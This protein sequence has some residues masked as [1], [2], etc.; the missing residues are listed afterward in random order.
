MKNT[1]EFLLI[2]FLCSA[3]LA[4]ESICAQPSAGSPSYKKMSARLDYDAVRLRNYKSVPRIAEVDFA[5]A[6][7]A[8][9]YVRL[10]SYGVMIIS[11]Q[12]RDPKELPLKSVYLKIGNKRF[13]LTCLLSRTV[14]PGSEN[15][16]KI[17]GS[18][19]MDSFYLIP[20]GYTKLKGLLCMD[21][22]NKREGFKLN[23][24]P[25]ASSLDFIRDNALLRPIKG[26]K[27]D[28][29]ALKNLLMREF[30]FT[31][32]D[33]LEAEHALNNANY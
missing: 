29:S 25:L 12:C 2:F 6:S 24:F 18:N 19:R 32:E 1:A 3:G 17:L 8:E 5:F 23:E 31:Q 15:A 30:S 26:K 33:V 20:Y 16:A 9:E 27:I 22:G 21:W 14:A 10:N 7:Y 28:R 4:V 13:P 11:A